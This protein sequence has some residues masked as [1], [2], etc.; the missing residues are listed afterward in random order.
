MTPIVTANTTFTD[1]DTAASLEKHLYVVRGLNAF[2]AAS[3]DS[4]RTGEFTFTR[5]PG[6]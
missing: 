1:T 6:H 2:A 5:V 4:G 3:A